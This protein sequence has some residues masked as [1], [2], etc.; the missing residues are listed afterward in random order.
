[1]DTR[2]PVV[3]RRPT[4]SDAE[5]E[6]RLADLARRYRGASGPGLQ[7]LNLVGGQAENLLERLP[8][9]IKDRL[10]GATAAALTS[11]YGAAAWSRGRVPDQAPWLNTA[12]ATALGAAGGFGGLPGAMAEIPVTV[13]VLFRAIQA[14][15]ADHGFDPAEDAIRREATLVF[16]A[17]GPLS[18]DDGSNTAFLAARAT[19]TGATLQALI[20]RVAP[21][22]S[23]ALGQ[24]LAAQTVPVLGAVAGAATN[25]AYTSYYQEIAA[26]RFGLLRLADDR[27]EPVEALLLRLERMLSAPG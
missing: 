10:E 22:L 14:Q 16:A 23:L 1:M 7:V 27:G 24:K 3:T 25:Y 26:V 15:A 8:D 17:A 9:T 13:T 4:P 21:R 19:I 18:R 11:A 5:T 6:A 2:L 12:V 20:A